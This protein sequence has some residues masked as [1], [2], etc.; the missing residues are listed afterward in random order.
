MLKK[1]AYI[2]SDQVASGFYL[3]FLHACLRQHPWVLYNEA[4]GDF[5]DDKSPVTAQVL[6]SI[7]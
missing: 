1:Q 7:M 4:L 6:F 3:S 2:Q 5:S